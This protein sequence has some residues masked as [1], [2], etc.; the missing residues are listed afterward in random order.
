MGDSGK[1]PNPGPLT[2]RFT[3]NQEEVTVSG[4]HFVQEDS[5]PEIGHAIAAW[6]LTQGL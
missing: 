6:L 2:Y 5:G 1:L 3:T 4:V